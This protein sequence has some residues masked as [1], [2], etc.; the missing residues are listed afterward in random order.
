[1][2]DDTNKRS[3]T[4]STIEQ[5]LSPIYILFYFYFYFYFYFTD[6][7]SRHSTYMPTVHHYSGLYKETVITETVITEM[8]ITELEIM[9]IMR[10]TVML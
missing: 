7:Y 8:E 10:I 1:M 9:V 3:D 4:F 2:S 6:L 5:N